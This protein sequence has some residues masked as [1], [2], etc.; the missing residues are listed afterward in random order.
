LSAG[1]HS[2]YKGYEED[3]EL[4]KKYSIK[5]AADAGGFY[6]D[7]G[8]DSLSLEH[9]NVGFIHACPGFVNTRWGTEFP[10]VVRGEHCNQYLFFFSPPRFY[11]DFCFYCTSW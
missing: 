11:I 4:K 6:N 3:I 9:P 10:A 8:L 1:V 7:I 2:P 5:N